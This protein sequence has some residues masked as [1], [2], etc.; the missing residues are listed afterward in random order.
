[1]ADTVEP[2][3]AAHGIDAPRAV[4]DIKDAKP[5]SPADALS[6]L[7]D[8]LVRA[9]RAPADRS[10]PNVAVAFSLG[11]QMAEL[12]SP[13]HRQQTPSSEERL[14]GIGSLSDQA[15]LGILVDQI[16][17]GLA[18]LNDQLSR[19]GFGPFDLGSLRVQV[20]SEEARRRAVRE[21]H[22]RV[23]GA[24]TAVDFRLGKAYGLGRALADTSRQPTNRASICEELEHHRLANLL[25]WLDDL[26]SALPAHAGHSVAKSL[27][28]WRDWA[29]QWR[30]QPA[31]R[32][33]RRQALSE[34]QALSR[35][36]RQ[37]ELWRALLSGEKSGGE[38]LEIDNWLD[39][40]RSFMRRIGRIA[41]GL[42][43][44]MPLLSMLIVGLF[45]AGVWLMLDKHNF[46]WVVAGAG[47]VLSSLGLTWKGIGGS[48]GQLAG[49]LEQPLFGAATDQAIADAITLLPRYQKKDRR[50]RASL[51][52]EMR[53]A[54]DSAS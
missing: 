23:L 15:R 31:S 20:S 39:V 44:R 29:K 14:P 16:Q 32:R 3:A 21:L 7:G 28:R 6:A 50:D 25:G 34:Q 2:T 1:M 19:A 5:G 37:G 8:A 49:R 51:A 40:A 10:D 35:L 13:H 53:R 22:M 11:W 33:A 18:K 9:A 30:R 24:L 41:R 36:R 47:G 52:L 54:T 12:Y 48:L 27:V 4:A 42:I 45:G 46:G 17:T 43:W 38:M 26:S